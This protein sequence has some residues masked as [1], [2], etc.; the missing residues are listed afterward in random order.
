VDQLVLR[1]AL[2]AA[3]LHSGFDNTLIAST[4][5]MQFCFFAAALARARIES[6]Q[7]QRSRRSSSP[8]RALA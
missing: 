7:P 8:R 2:V 5:V 3:L 4:A 1:C 6:E